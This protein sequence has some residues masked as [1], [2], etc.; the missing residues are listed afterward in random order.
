M[1]DSRLI[2]HSVCS[3]FLHS[4]AVFPHS[5]RIPKPKQR[6]GNSC[7]PFREIKSMHHHR[8]TPPFS[9]RR[10]TPRSQ[11]KQSYGIYHFLGKQGQRVYTIGPER[12]VY[13]IEPQTP[14]KKKRRV[15]TVVVYTFFFPAICTVSTHPIHAPPN[16]ILQCHELL[17]ENHG[18]FDAIL[19][20][21]IFLS[22][23]ASFL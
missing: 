19:P 9:V 14:K 20:P 18:G 21:S 2:V 4:A 10:P 16:M 11:S 3:S 5:K 6:G 13:T 23:A 15:S 1:N 8:G 17:Q 22:E 7:G 12:M